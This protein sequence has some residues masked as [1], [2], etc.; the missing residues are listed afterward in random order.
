MAGEP[1]G[2][3]TE[4]A[5]PQRMK[6]LRKEGAL[7]K[8]QDLSAWL[9]VGAAAIMMP[10]AIANGKRAGEDQFAPSATSSP[11]RPRTARSVFSPTGSAPSS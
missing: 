11:T 8:S 9:G 2:E 4:K 5:T 7:Q 1:A 10:M 6:K 3:K